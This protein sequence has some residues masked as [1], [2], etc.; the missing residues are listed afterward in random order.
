MI[1]ASEF[2]RTPVSENGNGQYFPADSA[3]ELTTAIEEVQTIAQT[4]PAPAPEPGQSDYGASQQFEQGLLVVGFDH[5][6]WDA[7]FQDQLK[8]AYL[9]VC[10]IP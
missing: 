8:I 3:E 4:E 6:D 9:T 1:W 10:Q 7:G 5:D 2:G